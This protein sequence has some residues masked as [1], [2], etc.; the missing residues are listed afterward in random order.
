MEII[1]SLE[2][3]DVKSKV[4]SAEILST[5]NLELT[6]ALAPGSKAYELFVQAFLVE[7][8]ASSFEKY[9]KLVSDLANQQE[10]EI[11]FFIEKGKVRVSVDEL[12]PLIN[13]CVHLFRN[14][15][16]HGIESAENRTESG[17]SSVAH[18]HLN[19]DQFEKESKEWIRICLQ[20]DGKGVNPKII[21]EK[22]IEK[23][24]RSEQQ[25]ASLSDTEIIQMIFLPQFSSL[26]NVTTLSGRGV[27]LDSINSEV[28]ALNGNLR[29]QSKV[30]QGTQFII[31]IPLT[32]SMLAKAS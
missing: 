19:F 7:D 11:E 2:E 20:D 9:K 22:L 16:D 32:N 13:S 8:I 24:I 14:V 31:E 6:K 29:V 25:L 10:K 18:V 5:L 4:V 30:G 17:K 26:D 28:K 1:G 23:G 27:G 21:K 12:K 3:G 15:V